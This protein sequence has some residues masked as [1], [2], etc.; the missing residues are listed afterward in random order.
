M[1]EKT[2][3][4][5]VNFLFIAS[6]GYTLCWFVISVLDKPLSWGLWSFTIFGFIAFQIIFKKTAQQQRMQSRYVSATPLEGESTSR[7]E[8]TKEANKLYP[9]YAEVDMIPLK[10]AIIGAVAIV[11]LIVYGNMAG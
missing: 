11:G 2:K 3:A 8:R 6:C 9:M 4:M 7:I 1:Q 5:L 10:V